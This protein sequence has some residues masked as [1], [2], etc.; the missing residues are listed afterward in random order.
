M[1]ESAEEFT[2]SDSA[3]PGV[4]ALKAPRAIRCREGC[5]LR[6]SASQIDR[7]AVSYELFLHAAVERG[8]WLSGDR[9]VGEVDAAG[10]LGWEVGSLRNARTEGAGP[11][12][13]RAGGGGSKITYRLHDLAVWLESRCSFYSSNYIQLHGEQDSG[14]V[15][16]RG[17][18]SKSP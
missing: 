1:I 15:L 17:G 5:E 8:C 7:A 12:Y 16:S 13:Y 18:G 6:L 3:P 2:H 4:R 10:L 14:V 9:R 11:T